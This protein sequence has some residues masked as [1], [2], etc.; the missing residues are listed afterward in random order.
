MPH[1]Y[2]ALLIYVAL[3][4][5]DIKHGLNYLA[6][7]FFKFCT[8]WTISTWIS[9]TLIIQIT[10]W[11]VI[12]IWLNRIFCGKISHS[13]SGCDLFARLVL[14]EFFFS[15]SIRGVTL[16][17]IYSI[18]MDTLLSHSINSQGSVLY[19]HPSDQCTTTPKNGLCFVRFCCDWSTGRFFHIAPNFHMI[20]TKFL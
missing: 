7:Q 20:S 8:L 18:V 1:G 11:F 5:C 2:V 17:I 19:T 6:A 13:V 10:W 14:C 9:N 12:D 16:Q 3:N 15:H 4:L